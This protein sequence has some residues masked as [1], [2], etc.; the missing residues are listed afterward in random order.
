MCDFIILSSL[1]YN[2]RVILKKTSS[3]ANFD[4]CFLKPESLI[5]DK[6]LISKSFL[7]YIGVHL[8]FLRQK[9]YLFK[10]PHRNVL[11]CRPCPKTARMLNIDFLNN[12][13]LLFYTIYFNA[14]YF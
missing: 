3:H 7:N 6:I 14:S 8:L 5:S 10:K 12:P 2:T 4:R 13:V 11:S 1:P 9:L